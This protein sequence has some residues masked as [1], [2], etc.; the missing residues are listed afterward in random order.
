MFGGIA[1]IFFPDNLPVMD[2]SACLNRRNRFEPC[3]LC[4][5]VCTSG[6]LSISAGLVSI[7]AGK[8]TGCGFCSAVCPSE[9]LKLKDYRIFRGIA[10]NGELRCVKSGGNIC[11]KALSPAFVSAVLVISP[12]MRFIMP[13][14]NCS[15]NEKILRDNLNIAMKFLDSLNVSHNAEIIR[16]ENFENGLSRRELL[17]SFFIW[18]KNKGSNILE[19]VIWHNQSGVFLARKFLADRLKNESGH[20]EAGVFYDFAVSENCNVCGFCEGICPS[21]AWKISKSDGKAALTFDATKCAGC[22]LCVRKCPENAI[23]FRK[24]FTWPLESSA[25][26]EAV[27]IRCRHCGKWFVQC[28]PENELC[29]QCSK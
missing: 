22:M 26:F 9:S 13:C 7:N 4:E 2:K 20:V 19:D 29:A 23:T 27:M 16:D 14:K 3:A 28:K 1:D 18:G 5:S 24:N 12:A 6:A 21:G 15:L 11:L 10:G 8:C 17:S 25:K